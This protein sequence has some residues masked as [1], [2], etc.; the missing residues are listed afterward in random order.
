[1]TLPLTT[2]TLTTDGSRIVLEFQRTTI[3]CTGELLSGAQFAGIGEP[4]TATILSHATAIE[5]VEGR[6]FAEAVR[7]R[8]QLAVAAA[9][10]LTQS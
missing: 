1:M 2:D 9:E 10:G 8:Y 3:A 7:E 4:N 5:D 6:A